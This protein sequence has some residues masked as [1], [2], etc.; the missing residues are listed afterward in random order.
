[1]E[2]Y[3]QWSANEERATLKGKFANDRHRPVYHF[4]PPHNWMN[5]PNGLI[6][7][8][9][10]YHMFYQ[11]NPLVADGGVILW[12]HAVSSDMLHWTDLPVALEP[13]P[14]TAD[15]GGCWSGITLDNG[16][17]PTIIYTGKNGRSELPCV[18]TSQD[19][20]VTWQKYEG[21]PV[22]AT[23]PAESV[24]TDFRDHTVW[25]EG[26][27]WY[28]GIG[29]GLKGG[30]GAV[31]LFSSPDLYHWTYLHPLYQGDA[32]VDREVY[33]CP[34]FFP[35]GDKHVLIFSSTTRSYPVAY[36]GT[37]ADHKFTPEIEER[38]DYGS[39]SFYAPQTFED[40][41]GRRVMW[42][43]LR[44]TRSR[45]EHRAANWAG[46]MT[47]PILITHNE[48]GEI[49]YSFAPETEAL[50][51]AN[52]EF[53]EQTVSGDTLLDTLQGDSLELKAEF[54]PGSATGFGLILR[55]SPDGSE[56]TRLG[57]D[58]NTGRLYLDVT[59]SNSEKAGEV[60]PE[61]PAY[62]LEPGQSLRFHVYLDRSVIEVSV[63]DRI[64]MS[65]RVYPSR[66]DSLGVGVFATGGEA[67]LKKLE[68]WQI[69]SIWE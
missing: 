11:Y 67:T 44:E 34:S 62:I 5:D 6:Q 14:G 57:Y 23:P 29:T 26:D 7:W 56:Q 36:I 42:S 21:N 40:E 47:M 52:L 45:E 10:L 35:L 46:V 39:N 20:L 38:M 61:V 65:G 30:G 64:Y 66:P 50:R 63:N 41:K 58:V 31:M 3:S 24:G 68:A 17:V 54:Q 48:A 15:A 33:E 13:T 2:V 25:R 59:R 19:N 53:G 51:G 27:T 22:I 18:A 69:G 28:M 49:C 55:S 1:M 32:G 9:G 12:G 8:Q 4:I 43:W 60:S 16:G 37:Y